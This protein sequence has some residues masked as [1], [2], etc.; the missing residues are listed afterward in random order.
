MIRLLPTRTCCVVLSTLCGLAYANCACH[1]RSVLEPCCVLLQVQISSCSSN[2]SAYLHRL[3][4]LVLPLLVECFPARMLCIVCILQHFLRLS[5]H[6]STMLQAPQHIT[7]QLLKGLLAL[8]CLCCSLA[9][10]ENSD[11]TSRTAGSCP[12]LSACG[13]TAPAAG[14]LEHFCACPAVPF[15][16]IGCQNITQGLSLC[17][18]TQLV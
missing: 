2:R 6:A 13:P 17:A 5:Q 4:H 11:K 3:K 1:H 16:C 9:L 8:S 15:S 14:K 7:V 12:L 18:W 10:W